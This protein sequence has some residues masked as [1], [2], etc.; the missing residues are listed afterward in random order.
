MKKTLI[1]LLVCLFIIESAAQVGGPAPD[2]VYKMNYKVELP[3]TAGM[4]ALNFLG[5]TQLSNKPTLDSTDIIALNKDDIWGFDRIT[6]NQSV[7]APDYIYTLS[8]IGLW[9]SYALPFLLLFDDEI[10]KSWLDFTL[11]Y[12]ETQAIN[13]NLY[14][15]GGPVFTERIRPVIYNEGSWDYKLENGTT[16]SFFTAWLGCYVD[17]T[18]GK[19]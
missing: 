11:L 16:D 17:M 6:F 12:F 10:R 2:K 1:L 5:F 4:F 9:T 18:L 3:L 8:D 15:W 14:V 19:Y 13:L 7:P